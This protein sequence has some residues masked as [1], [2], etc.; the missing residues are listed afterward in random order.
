MH[1]L[2]FHFYLCHFNVF[3]EA[4]QCHYSEKEATVTGMSQ[5]N[6][7]VRKVNFL[8]PDRVELHCDGNG[9]GGNCIEPSLFGTCVHLL[10]FSL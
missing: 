3:I 8:V 9:D 4:T 5:C 1:F 10:P 7:L 2:F 6:T